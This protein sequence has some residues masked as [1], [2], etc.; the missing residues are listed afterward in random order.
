VLLCVPP[1]DAQPIGADSFL[2]IRNTTLREYGPSGALLRAIPV[3]RMIGTGNY[4]RDLVL[5]ADGVV[6]IFN[7]TFDPY[8]SAYDPVTDNWSHTTFLGW[9]IVNV[10]Y[11]GGIVYFD[12]KVFLSDHTTGGVGDAPK[13]IVQIDVA[14]GQG[15]RFATDI[16]PI[17]LSMGLDGW[18]YALHPTGSPGGRTLDA[19]DPVSLVRVERIDLTRTL[20]WTSNQTVAVAASGDLFVGQDNEVLRLDHLGNIIASLAMPCSSGCTVADIDLAPDGTMLV[21]TWSHEV[22]VSDDD[23]TAAAPLSVP[24]WTEPAASFVAFGTYFQPPPSPLT[25]TPTETWTPTITRTSTPTRTPTIT[26]TATITEAPTATDTPTETPTDTPEPSATPSATVTSTPTATDSPTPLPPGACPLQPSLGCG[27]AQRSRLRINDYP[28][29]TRDWLRWAWQRGEVTTAIGD[30]TTQTTYKICIYEPTFDSHR[31]AL[32][33]AAP[34]G[35]TCA[36]RPCWRPRSRGGFEYDDRNLDPDGIRK[37]IV[38]PGADGRATLMVF[39]KGA[40][41]Q[42]PRLPLRDDPNVIVQVLTS[43]PST[44]CWEATYGREDIRQVIGE[45]ASFIARK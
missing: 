33:A 37:L 43:D 11:Y 17:D 15:Q 5:G 19:Y 24:S 21:G 28:D 27:H 2:V 14:N 31:L 18:L 29:P 1:A 25:R 13:G 12:G 10:T 34:A 26:S 39:A 40:N 30:P 38:V 3:P 22:F 16:E 6:Y 44:A 4:A 45:R 32:E 20:G 8:L 9:S 7:G 35:G 23:L 41:L 36:D 42:V